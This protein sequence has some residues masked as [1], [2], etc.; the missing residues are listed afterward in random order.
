MNAKTKKLINEAYSALYVL[1]N[2][3]WTP[4]RDQLFELCRDEEKR[5]RG[6]GDRAWGATVNDCARMFV[7]RDIVQ[8]LTGKTEV[9]PVKFYLSCKK[10][11][12][13]A[14]ALVENYREE[15]TKAL[16]GH[17]LEAIAA[18]DYVE[19]IKL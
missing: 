19:I 3:T 10:S 9:P 12:F 5:H 18:L 1:N 11:C 2:I 7:V 6:H 4:Y 16:A 8:Y 14:A 17:D 13:M 15:I